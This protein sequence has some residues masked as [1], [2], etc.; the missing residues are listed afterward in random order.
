M[1]LKVREVV[2]LLEQN[3]WVEMRSKGSHRHFK[4]LAHKFVT[5]VPGQDGQGT[6]AGHAERYTQ[7]GR[8][9]MKR[10][11]VVIEPTSTGF[12]AYSPDVPGCAAVG[13]T[14]EEARRNFREALVEHFQAM[15]EIGAPIPEP[16]TSVDYVD[17]AA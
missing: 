14:E 10:Y 4:H 17:V 15:R 8:A 11:P 3:G 7:N 16:Q 6:R 2:R 12:S 5:T 13:D 1:P 9:K